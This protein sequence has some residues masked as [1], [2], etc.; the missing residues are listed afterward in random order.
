MY[1]Y[2]YVTSCEYLYFVKIKVSF[3]NTFYE[4]NHI[5]RFV[6]KVLDTRDLGIA[7]VECGGKVL[8]YKLHDPVKSFGSKLEINLP[9]TQDLE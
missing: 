5:I 8:E 6:G 2:V 3:I 4:N 9:T 1:L 7:K